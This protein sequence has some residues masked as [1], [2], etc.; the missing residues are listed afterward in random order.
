MILI[1]NVCEIHNS[2]SLLSCLRFLRHKPQC[3]AIDAEALPSWFRTIIEHMPEMTS[4]L[5][6]D[7]CTDHPVR[8]VLAEDDC[9]GRNGAREAW[10]ASTG[11]KFILG[12][13]EGLAG[14]YSDEDT[15]SML[16]VEWAR[17][18]CFCPF[19]I[20]DMPL[21]IC[22]TV[23]TGGSAGGRHRGG[24]GGRNT[25]KGRRGRKGRKVLWFFG[26]DTLLLSACRD[27][28]E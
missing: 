15:L 10:P 12:T 4:A 26:R 20:E 7:F 2:M 16:I 28:D 13:E 18:G 11:V 24:G 22:E 25:G 6:C 23:A 8:I 3:C 27:K 9:V 14:V 21:L 5:R 1:H 19:G 17:K